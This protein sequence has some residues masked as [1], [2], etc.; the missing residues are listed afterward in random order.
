MGW[1]AWV[2]IAIFGIY[3]GLGCLMAFYEMSQTD[4]PWNWKIVAFWPL[5]FFGFMR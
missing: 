2:L 4:D 3:A 1:L 5:I